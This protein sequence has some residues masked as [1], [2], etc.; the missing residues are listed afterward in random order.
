MFCVLEWHDKSFIPVWGTIMIEYN[1]PK[2]FH[3]VLRF[4]SFKGTG[5]WEVVNF[6]VIHHCSPLTH[7][8]DLL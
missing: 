3:S 7:L 2:D 5:S 1:F 8:C 4:V 6:I